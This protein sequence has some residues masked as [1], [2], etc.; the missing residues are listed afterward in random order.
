MS[1]QDSMFMQL[2]V[3]RSQ[4]FEV[5]ELL[6]DA[7]LDFQ[8]EIIEGMIRDFRERW[9]P[10]FSVSQ[11]SVIDAYESI[12]FRIR[13]REK[14]ASSNQPGLNKPYFLCRKCGTHE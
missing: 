5:L 6:S 11:S 3:Y 10:K 4:L 7:Q 1:D 9:G 14:F 2:S 8:R 12:E 13:H